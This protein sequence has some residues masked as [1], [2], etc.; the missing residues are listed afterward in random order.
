MH[1]EFK[2]PG[3]KLVVVDLEV[4]DG[5]ISEFR[6]S[7]DFF[8]EPDE[9]L[10]AIDAAV[11]G[12]PA[13][14]DARVYAAAVTAALPDDA[15]LLG[16]SPDSVATAIRRALKQATSWNDYDW[17]LLHPGPLSPRMHL[18]LDQVLAEEVGDGRRKPTLRI[19][20]WDE[21]AVVIGSF[22]SVKNEVDPDNAAKYGFDVVR[23]ISGGG[24][25]FMDAGSVVTY[26]LY[27]PI[28]LVQGMSFADSYAFF[29][30][31]VIQALKSLGIEASY[32]P[33]NDITSPTGK[34][35]GAAQKRL[36]NGAVLHH[37]TM[38]YDMDGD[39][40][41]QVLR[42]GREKMSDKG[43]KSANKR[44]DPLRSQ[45]GLSRAEIIERMIATF[46]GLHGLHDDELRPEEIA[47]AEQLVAEKFGTDE[48]LYRVP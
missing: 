15:Q 42:I 44:V 1:G 10:P 34:I 3:G 37:V 22:Q 48:W 35:G 26:S 47:A 16:F 6:L 43:T 40:M 14:A 30:E 39:K 21:P 4:A 17:Q 20:E 28:D 27:A 12:L 8:L 11:L 41:V 13:D 31:W 23:R 45:T 9:A 19:W 32:Q 46:R 24:A 7:G 25:M 36:G 38:S 5:R 2:V 29:D 18:A 33:L